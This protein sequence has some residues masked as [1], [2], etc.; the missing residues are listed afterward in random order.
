M[1]RIAVA[2]GKGG[3]GKTTVAVSLAAILAR[4]HSVHL[5]DC[6]VEAPNAGIFLRPVIETAELVMRPVPVVDAALCD[7]CGECSRAC[8][9]HAIATTPSRVL[10]FPGLCHGCGGCLRACPRG[11]ITDKLTPVGEVRS[12]W[13]GRIRFAEGR[14][15]TG[16]TATVRLIHAVRRME[17][18]AEFVILDAPPGTSCPLAATLSG[19][20]RVVLVT[21]PTPFGLNDLSLAVETARMLG[22]RLGIV[23][24]RDG[25]GDGRVDDYCAS[26]GL[27]VIGRIP[28][29]RLVAEVYSRG[30]L[31]LAAVPEFREALAGIAAHLTREVAA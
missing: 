1:I 13:A 30:E 16:S 8:R 29:N 27:E 11:A 18:P 23:I 19:V 17:T 7:L 5:L 4:K 24:N 22:L 21:E 15:N 28:D 12:G 26:S 10:T 9:F 20:D 25:A 3:A 2:S 14:L 31:P 6:D